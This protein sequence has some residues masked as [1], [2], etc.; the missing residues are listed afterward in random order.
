MRPDLDERP[1]QCARRG[2]R[3]RSRAR[4]GRSQQ[5]EVRPPRRRRSTSPP[6]RPPI[7]E[8]PA[9]QRQPDCSDRGRV[10]EREAVHEPVRCERE[11]H[12]R[13]SGQADDDEREQL[14]VSH[15]ASQLGRVARPNSAKMRSWNTAATS[16]TS[17]R[18]SA[19]PSS[20]TSDE[21]PG[22]SS[23]ASASVLDEHD[24]DH[25]EQAARRV[26]TVMSPNATSA[27]A[28]RSAS[29]DSSPTVARARSA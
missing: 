22:S 21:V 27:S 14:A 29:D 18:S 1:G 20:I 17:V 28:A 15:G 8:R 10:R 16:A 13:E 12:S 4:R 23:A 11:Q 7:G 26:A 25:L 19:T 9:R 3:A 2:R 24:P 6:R 5:R